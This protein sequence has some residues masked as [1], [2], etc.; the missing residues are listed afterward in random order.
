[1]GHGEVFVVADG[2]PLRGAPQHV[3]ALGLWLGVVGCELGA[4]R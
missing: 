4:L 2:H 3:V 1:L